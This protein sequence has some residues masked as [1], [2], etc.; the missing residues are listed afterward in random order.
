M[1]DG[2]K[3]DRRHQLGEQIVQIVE[4]AVGPH[5][6]GFRGKR[7]LRRQLAHQLG[8]R[9]QQCDGM[10][11]VVSMQGDARGGAAAENVGDAAHPIDG[12]LRVAGGDEDVH[13][14]AILSS[15]RRD[16]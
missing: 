9:S 8:V 11:S 5:G 3:P 13:T 4:C 15:V 2:L 14:M 10:A 12:R 16:S 1:D 6:P 7:S